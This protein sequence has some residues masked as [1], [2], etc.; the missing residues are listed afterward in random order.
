MIGDFYLQS[1]KIAKYKDE[2][3]KGV[4]I[5]SLEYYVA[6]LLTVLPVFCLDMILAATYAAIIH[7]VIDTIKYLIC[8]KRIIKKSCNVFIVDQCV[9]ISSF[10][11]LAYTLDYFDFS[12]GNLKYIEY[13][14]TTFNLNFEIIARWFLSI[15]FIHKPVNIFIKN[16]LGEYKPK[17]NNEIV[18]TDN[19]AGR[20][21]GTI[22]RLIM[23]IFLSQNQFAALGFVLTAKSIARY[24]K[25]TKDEKFAE[26]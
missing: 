16:F 22:E 6:F 25:I 19:K 7:F 24:D 9:H 2:K 11:V 5:H 23:L 14:L 20:K 4:L 21:I 10:F 17:E 3:Y 8:R 12:I 18:M 1:D 13:W 15:L 26:Y